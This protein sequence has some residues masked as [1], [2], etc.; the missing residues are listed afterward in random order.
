M[1][2]QE[3]LN[4]FGIREAFE[5]ASDLFEGN[6]IV[7]LIPSESGKH[8]NGLDRSCNFTAEVLIPSESGK[9]SND[10]AK[11][12]QSFNPTS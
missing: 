10:F 8:S 12:I 9:H 4:P 7:V 1:D 2:A 11:M 5:P 3:G 6:F